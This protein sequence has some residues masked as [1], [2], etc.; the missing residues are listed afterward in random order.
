MWYKTFSARLMRTGWNNVEKGAG[1]AVWNPGGNASPADVKR[2]QIKLYFLP[3][4][5]GTPGR[6]YAATQGGNPAR[7]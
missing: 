4:K 2:L 7:I 6:I 1:Y 5:D 3:K